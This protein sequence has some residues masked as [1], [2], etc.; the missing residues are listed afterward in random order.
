MIR[1]SELAVSAHAQYEF[2]QKHPNDW[3]DVGWPSSCNAFAIVLFLVYFYYI[4][5]NIDF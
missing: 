2:G 1:S 4:G 3:Y 5:N